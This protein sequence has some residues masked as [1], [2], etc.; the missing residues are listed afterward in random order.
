VGNISQTTFL[1]YFFFAKKVSKEQLSIEEIKNFSQKLVGKIE[2]KAI[3]IS[4]QICL[5][6]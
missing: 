3:N 5:H 4:Q 2:A 1:R 6:S